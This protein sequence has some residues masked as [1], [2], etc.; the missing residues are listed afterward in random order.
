MEFLAHSSPFEVTLLNKHLTSLMFSVCYQSSFRVKTKKV[1][2][3][4]GLTL[5]DRARTSHK[6]KN[7][8]WN[9]FP[10]NGTN[11]LDKLMEAEDAGLNA[12]S[13]AVAQKG[14]LLNYYGP[15]HIW[16]YSKWRNKTS[17]RRP[18]SARTESRA[19]S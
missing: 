12:S 18:T 13:T 9:V 15:R 19:E 17:T 14:D 4:Q 11:V 5:I 6:L 7:L 3:L 2:Y 8:F 1:E 16:S 10:E